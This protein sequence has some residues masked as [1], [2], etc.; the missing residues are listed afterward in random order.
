MTRTLQAIAILAGVLFCAGRA[1]MAIQDTDVTDPHRF[2]QL[3]RRHHQLNDALAG[4]VAAVAN[5][6]V[7]ASGR[8]PRAQV[9]GPYDPRAVNVY[10]VNLGRSGSGSAKISG[11]GGTLQALPAHGIILADA[12]YLSDIKAATDVYMI[13]KRTKA[14][15]LYTLA[16]L[17]GADALERSYLGS[18]ADWRQGRNSVFDGAIA[19]LLSHE[20]GHLVAGIHAQAQV[21]EIPPHNHEQAVRRA[22]AT[23]LG[24]RNQVRLNDERQADEYAISL[25]GSIKRPSGRLRYE[26][27]TVVLG[28]GEM[29]KTATAMAALSPSVEALAGPTGISPTMINKMRYRLGQGGE[30]FAAVFPSSHPASVTRLLYAVLRLSQ[31]PDSAF[32]GDRDPRNHLQ[33]WG[34]LTRRM[35]GPS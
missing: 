3:L 23:I 20:M 29:R 35:C 25:V 24:D 21:I 9:N 30:T 2:A 26:F 17:E 28:L 7:R 8:W 27:G 31:N 4:Q 34:M 10:L 14:G 32:Y 19:F 6:L 5:T 1:A 11:L 33:M 22:C 12:D 16:I 13:R 18:R 15:D